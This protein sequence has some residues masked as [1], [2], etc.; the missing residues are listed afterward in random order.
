MEYEGSLPHSQERTT[1]PYPEHTV[2]LPH[3][4]LC[5]HSI[6]VWVFSVTSF[7]PWIFLTKHFVCFQLAT[8]RHV[9]PISSVFT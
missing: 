9:T 2:L 3:R 6:H 5:H 1:C 7:L 8:V 4:S